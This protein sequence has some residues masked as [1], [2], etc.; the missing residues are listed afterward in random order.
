MPLHNGKIDSS[1]NPFANGEI[2]T[3]LFYKE[4]IKAQGRDANANVII[5]NT[6]EILAGD[7]NDIYENINTS[8]AWEMPEEQSGSAFSP[9][10]SANARITPFGTAFVRYAQTTRFPNL[11]ELTSSA[12]VD[13]AGTVGSLAEGAGKPERSTNWEVGYAHDLRQ[14]FPSVDFA[15]VRLSYY[16]TE[17]RDFI[18]RAR[19]YD[20]I[21]YDKKKTSGV[22]L[23]SRFDSGR[24][25]GSLGVTYR[26][27]QKL[28][29][30]DYASELDP[31]YNR[32]PSCMTGGFPGT[33][34]GSSLQPKYSID[35]LLG[36]RLLSN[37]LELGWRSVYHAEAENKQLD[38]LLASETGPSYL[39]PRDVWFR[40]G[41]DTFHW[42]S[43]LLHDFYLRYD[44]SRDVTL[45][46]NVNNL[47]D[48]YYLD[49]MSKVLLPGPGR[50]ISAGVTVKF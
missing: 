19:L 8:Q 41:V 1:R 29:D 34:S 10:F 31:F 22:E 36:T 32:I 5:A 37:R 13:G 2:D 12:I 35:L 18:E 4:S 33:Y 48:E 9:V 40:G 6:P 14:F 21:Q 11:H 39:L 16:N 25:F 28:C 7:I 38:R 15:D 27:K 26:I 49:P 43:V 24:Y 46:L 45:N 17:I 20:L 50:T 30:K 23:Q 44:L 42:R 47:T 3:E